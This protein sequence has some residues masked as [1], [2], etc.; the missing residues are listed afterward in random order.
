ML[1]FKNWTNKSVVTQPVKIMR[2]LD[3]FETQMSGV[4][5]EEGNGVV[6]EKRE[7]KCGEV[8]GFVR[9]K[10]ILYFYLLRRLITILSLHIHPPFVRC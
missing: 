6:T 1:H 10:S 8:Q 7:R 5:K 4:S 9:V 2:R 3:P